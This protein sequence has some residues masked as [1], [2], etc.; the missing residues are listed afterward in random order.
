MRQLD[1]ILIAALIGALLYSTSVFA[2]YR[3]SVQLITATGE[4]IPH[5]KLSFT[6]VTDDHGEVGEVAIEEN[7]SDPSMIWLVFPG[8]D[9][10]AGTLTVA[11]PDHDVAIEIPAADN[12]EMIIVDVDSGSAQVATSVDDDAAEYDNAGHQA[13]ADDDNAQAAADFDLT[14]FI[15]P[16]IIGPRNEVGTESLGQKAVKGVIGSTLGGFL[17]GGSRRSSKSQAPKTRRDPTRRDEPLVLNNPAAQAAIGIRT[18]WTDDGL[19]LSFNIKESDDRGTF[20]YVYV[21]DENGRMLLPQNIE[22]YKIWQKHTL[23]VSWTRSEYIDGALVSRTSGGWSESWTTDLG[24]FTQHSDDT[25][26]APGIWQMA[27]FDRAH[28]GLRSIGATFDIDPAQLSALG[29]LYVIVHTTRPS[30]DPV[31]TVPFAAT[32]MFNHVS[33][34]DTPEL[35]LL[36]T[37]TLINPEDL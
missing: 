13:D 6:P 20:Q 23:T 7:E 32:L 29:R 15:T 4:A 30:L 5:T 37:P 35:E 11:M 24:T 28:A 33:V 9:S 27:G 26:L 18:K 31:T 8:D 17:G 16:I 25:V 2:V 19:L 36:L 3:Q 21:V 22:I 12:G 10:M 1:R 14:P 34:T